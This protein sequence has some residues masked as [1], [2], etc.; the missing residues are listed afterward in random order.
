[1]TTHLRTRLLAGALFT[2]VACTATPDEEPVAASTN[3]QTAAEGCAPGE[4]STPV[5]FMPQGMAWSPVAGVGRALSGGMSIRNLSRNGHDARVIFH[6]ADGSTVARN[7]SIPLVMHTSQLV[8]PPTGVAVSAAT[9]C[10]KE[11]V[12][13]AANV[14]LFDGGRA[15]AWGSYG[16]S[17]EIGVGARLV[18]PLLQRDNS[19]WQSLLVL[20]NPS[21]QPIEPV[22]TLS[23]GI[24]HRVGV[25]RPKATVTVDPR[26][27]PGLDAKVP[28]ARV[29]SN[30]SAPLSAVVLQSNGETMMAYRGFAAEDASPTPLL[31]L[32]NANNHGFVTGVQVFNAGDVA[33]SVTIRYSPAKGGGAGSVVDE[34]LTVPANGS[35]TFALELFARLGVT[36][37]GTARV[38]ANSAGVPLFATVNQVSSAKRLA[39]AYS[40][41]APERGSSTIAFPLIVNE[42]QITGIAVMNATAEP[43]TVTCTF[44]PRAD[45]MVQDK[46]ILRFDLGPFE[47]FSR[48][49]DFLANPYLGSG[50][51]RASNGARLVGVAN[52]LTNQLGV[53]GFLVHEASMHPQPTAPSPDQGIPIARTPDPNDATCT[54]PV[55]EPEIW[56]GPP[57]QP[58]T[59]CYSYASNIFT[60][61]V[62]SPSEPSHGIPGL[63]GDC[64]DCL[65][66][67]FPHP[68][69]LFR[70]VEADGFTPIA[71][72][73]P[74]PGN[75]YKIAAV[76]LGQ[77][78]QW[79]FWRQ[80]RDGYWS[81]I[82]TAGATARRLGIDGFPVTDVNH[83]EGGATVR[84][85][86]GCTAP[87]QGTGM[88][89][90]KGH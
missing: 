22:I 49:T 17:R 36:F 46:Q 8:A 42:R 77:L 3:A 58:G 37:V 70:A 9:V 83:E 23:G 68:S 72:D 16:P 1:M 50:H 87:G 80:D 24:E 2:L 74:C 85:F 34:T 60:K 52:Q 86:C 12:A 41:F 40:A 67:V 7:D 61:S 28:W 59:N 4:Q 88:Q 35:K 44:A 39:D 56:N 69:D 33:T 82:P 48:V 31:P 25:L 26:K 20:H 64:R 78:F 62:A 43:T 29:T 47:G 65:L 14:G 79:H 10:A 15:T 81:N 19:G 27:I 5:T 38:V 54:L 32:V 73:A 90:V 13:V 76:H 63:G 57:Q 18:L 11:P 71:K 89:N 45:G 30:D 55:Y 21:T 75:Q 53:D 84:Y 66:G 51:C 6:G